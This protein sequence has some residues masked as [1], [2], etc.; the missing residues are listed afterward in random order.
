[1]QNVL[2]DKLR[3]HC[4]DLLS[5]ERQPKVDLVLYALHHRKNQVL[6]TVSRIR[7]FAHDMGFERDFDS[8]W[9]RGWRRLRI[10]MVRECDDGA[11]DSDDGNDSNSNEKQDT[12]IFLSPCP[13]QQSTMSSELGR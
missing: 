5:N 10:S 6:Q 11:C 3:A 8:V 9:W 12:A 13:S 2:E 4:A 7:T 1:M